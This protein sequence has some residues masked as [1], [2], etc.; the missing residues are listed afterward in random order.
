MDHFTHTHWSIVVF[1]SR[2]SLI[3]LKQT[4]VAAQ[5]AAQDKANIEIIVNGNPP[6]AGDV[7]AWV[8]S[9]PVCEAIHRS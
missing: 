8:A 6:L 7:A 5:I 2:E 4:V 1:S 9:L 3:V